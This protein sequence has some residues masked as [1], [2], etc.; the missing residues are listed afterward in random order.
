MIIPK[1]AFRNCCKSMAT[2]G[3]RFGK[4]SLLLLQTAAEDRLN[5][6]FTHANEYTK[7]AGRKTL[8]LKDFELAVKLQ[9]DKYLS[10]V[11]HICVIQKSVVRKFAKNA[12]ALRVSVIGERWVEL[13]SLC[14]SQYTHRVISHLESSGTV[15][16]DQMIECLIRLEFSKGFTC[17][18]CDRSFSTQSGVDR[19]KSSHA[20]DD[21]GDE[22]EED[23]DL[24]ERMVR[25]NTRKNK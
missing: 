1:A 25:F 4:P 2:K 11:Q 12:G 9:D 6:L 10:K 19:C 15:S 17:A 23:D 8:S 22:T 16:L 21:D 3:L 7:H 18:D 14:I 13:V 24:S 20:E 5:E